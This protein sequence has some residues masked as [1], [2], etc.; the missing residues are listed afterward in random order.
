MSSDGGRTALEAARERAAKREADRQA[1]L[2]AL[3]LERLELE[4][5]GEADGKQIGV[6]F[7]VVTTMVGNFVV[8][9]PDFLTAKKFADKDKKSVEDVVAFVLPCITFPDR[10][11]LG[12]TFQEHGGISH[13]LAISLMRMYEASAVSRSGE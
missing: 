3:E 13:R 11:A 8:K 6:D 5:S 1:R 9:K 7:D 2:D 12:T 10:A 4:E